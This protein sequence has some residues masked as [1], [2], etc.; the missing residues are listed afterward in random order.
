LKALVF[1]KFTKLTIA[2]I[3]AIPNFFA[4]VELLTLSACE[5]A[6]GDQAIRHQD[7]QGVE[8]E[9]LGVPSTP[10]GSFDNGVHFQSRS[11]VR[12]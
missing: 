3:G 6:I 10:A 8:A 5:T 2:Q 12:V 11:R 1:P 4:E 7:H 9:S